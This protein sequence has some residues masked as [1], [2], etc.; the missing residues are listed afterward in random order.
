[1]KPD[2][3]P[4]LA[5]WTRRSTQFDMMPSIPQMICQVKNMALNSTSFERWPQLQN[6]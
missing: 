1:M 3:A 2:I 5:P 6:A 4:F